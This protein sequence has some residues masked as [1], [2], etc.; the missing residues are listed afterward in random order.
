M[1]NLGLRF[2]Q[3]L[4]LFKMIELESLFDELQYN[5]SIQNGEN[6]LVN[7][8]PYSIADL[9]NKTLLGPGEPIVCLLVSVRTKQE[10]IVW[11]HTH[12]QQ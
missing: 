7:L 8:K 9:C 3:E 1:A 10:A 12:W 5:D 4:L 11:L 2:D 6:Y